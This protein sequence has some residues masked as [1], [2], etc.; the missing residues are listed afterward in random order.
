MEA[1]EETDVTDVTD[2]TDATDLP[3]DRL[4]RKSNYS[5]NFCR[6]E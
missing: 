5:T 2:A 6:I 4:I 1:T 3:M